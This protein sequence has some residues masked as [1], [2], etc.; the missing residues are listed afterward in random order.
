MLAKNLARDYKLHYVDVKALTQSGVAELEA[1]AAR[2]VAA[3]TAGKDEDTENNGN[4]NGAVRAAEA[5]QLLDGIRESREKNGG[6]IADHFVM[7]FVRDMLN[8]IPCQHQGFVLDGYPESYAA[9]RDL[10][11]VVRPHAGT[12]NKQ[13]EAR[14]SEPAAVLTPHDHNIMPGEIRLPF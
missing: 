4:K 10:F 2:H 8:S 13:A 3:M 5:V 9:A 12:G 1:A 7:R 6:R 11:T 14:L